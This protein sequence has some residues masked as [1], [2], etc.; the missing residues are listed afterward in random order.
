MIFILNVLHNDYSLLVA[1]REGSVA[2]PVTITIGNITINAAQGAKIEG[3]RKLKISKCGTVAVGIAGSIM[4]H[5]YFNAFDNTNGVDESIRSILRSIEDFFLSPD[6][7]KNLSQ[8]TQMQNEGIATFFD[9]V[10]SQYF[11]V[12]YLYTH[13]QATF[14]WHHVSSS[15]AM[16][17]HVGSGSD[18][19]EKAVGLEEINRFIGSINITPTPDACIDW[20]KDAYEKVSRVAEGVG[21]EPELLVSTRSEPAF[22]ALF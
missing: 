11:S 20:I 5:E 22:K 10:A 8:L 19:F 15:G 13:V 9:A 4:D 6:R 12:L 16:L 2:G 17:L 21:K 7:K 1:D 18:Q 3:I 14:R